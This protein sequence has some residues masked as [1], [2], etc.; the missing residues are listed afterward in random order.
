MKIIYFHGGENPHSSI[1]WVPWCETTLKSG[2]Y[3]GIPIIYHPSFRGFQRDTTTILDQ[4]GYIMKY[5][6]VSFLKYPLKTA[7]NIS[8]YWGFP[9]KYSQISCDLG[10]WQSFP[11]QSN[12]PIWDDR[13][14]PTG[15]IPT[16]R[17]SWYVVR[18]SGLSI[19]SRYVDH[20]N[21]KNRRFPVENWHVV[22]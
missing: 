13:D 3:H 9:Q 20:V 14:D 11:K 6:I 8:R 2:L 19:D 16:G 7:W 22:F 1:T 21:T 15:T 18:S 4:E 10:Q 12:P 17:M 5:L